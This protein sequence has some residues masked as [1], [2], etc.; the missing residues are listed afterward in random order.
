M[1][2]EE[3]QRLYFI[4]VG[5]AIVAAWYWWKYKKKTLSYV[6]Q[7][8]GGDT[9]EFTMTNNSTSPQRI[10][11]FNP[12]RKIGGGDAVTVDAQGTSLDYFTQS[13]GTEPKKV[14]SIRIMSDKHAGGAL[15]LSGQVS[16]PIEKTCTDASGAGTDM[17]YTPYPDT[18]SPQGTMS[19]LKPDAL[20]LDGKCHIEYTI[21]PKSTV[22]WIIDY[23]T[24][25]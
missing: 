19:V 2:A 14:N 7:P 18:Y 16:A 11:L 1:K 25:K 13:L 20:I 8:A 4:L 22:K 12:T 5:G 15:G 21:Q 24:H 3:K 6:G 17:T 10:H 23:Q 9:V